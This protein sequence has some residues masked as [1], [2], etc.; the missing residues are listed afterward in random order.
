M[1][2]FAGLGRFRLSEVHECVV[3]RKGGMMVG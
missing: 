1:V 2:I 3:L